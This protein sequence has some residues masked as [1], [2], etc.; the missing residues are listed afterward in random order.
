MAENDNTGAAGAGNGDDQIA[1]ATALYEG[2]LLLESARMA[3]ETLA[4]RDKP[5]TVE[6]LNIIE[7]LLRQAGDAFEEAQKAMYQLFGIA[8]GHA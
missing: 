3:I 1:A 6:E 2:R 7:K 8:I 4:G 5:A